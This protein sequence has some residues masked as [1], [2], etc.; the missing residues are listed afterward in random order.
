MVP[1]LAVAVPLVFAAVTT[2]VGL[3]LS[4]VQSNCVAAVLLFPELS[5]N[6]LAATFIE[7]APFEVGVK[8]A[9]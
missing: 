2:T 9:E 1:P 4:N 5:V 3:T 6:L 8:L 7:V